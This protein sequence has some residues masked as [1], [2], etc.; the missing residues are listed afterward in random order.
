M[1]SVKTLKFTGTTPALSNHA[2][3]YTVPPLRQWKIVNYLGQAGSYYVFTLNGANIGLPSLSSTIYLGAG[4]ILGLYN[5]HSVSI[6]NADITVMLI[7][8]VADDYIGN[9]AD[10]VTLEGNDAAFFQDASNLNAGTV[11][12]ARMDWDSALTYAQNEFTT[13]LG[14]PYRSLQ[15]SNSNKQPNLNT[16]WWEVVGGGG[17]GQIN[18]AANSLRSANLTG[19]TRSAGT[20]LSWSTATPLYGGGALLIDNFQSGQTVD[21]NLNAVD[22]V[23]GGQAWK[24]DLGFHIENNSTA[25]V[26]GEMTISLLDGS[27]EIQGGNLPVIVGQVSRV[28]VTA[29]PPQTL[30]G[31][32]VRIKA[33]G[34]GKQCDLRIADL[35]VS[36]WNGV[37]VPAV[38][39]G[40]D[41]TPTIENTTFTT[42]YAKM[43]RIG[44]NARFSFRGLATAVSGEIRFNLPNGL[45]IDTIGMANGGIL[46]V[47]QQFNTSSGN[48]IIGSVM[49][50]NSTSK[51]QFR[52][53]GGSSWWS[54]GVPATWDANTIL[55]FDFT[56][57]IAQ[58]SSSIQVSG[59][60][61]EYAYNT[62]TSNADSE[63]AASAGYGPEGVSFGSYTAARRKR[64]YFRSPLKD[65]DEF[66]IQIKIS[67]TSVWTDLI[68]NDPQTGL[69]SFLYQN[70]VA[71]GIGFIR[72]G[73][74]EG[75]NFVTVFFGTYAYA[76]GVYGAAGGAWSGYT[77]HRWRVVKRSGG[78]NAA[79]PPVVRAEYYNADAAAINVAINFSTKSEDTHNAVTIGAGTWKFTAPVSGVY[80]VFVQIQA[81]STHLYEIRKGG[82]AVTPIALFP[83][84]NMGAV[85]G[86]A[87]GS[88]T[89]RLNAGEYID[90]RDITGSNLSY[91]SSS[92]Q[93]VRIGS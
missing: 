31:L 75:S 11:A 12:P 85:A 26:D 79:V 65:S 35:S 82:A 86:M 10:A 48:M 28:P 68:G 70:T 60:D 61:V 92:I 63:T 17:T 41:F 74:Y 81:T 37:S 62:D 23:Y 84:V 87:I 22:P 20:A 58:W 76:S 14:I 25:F 93:I 44:K 52:T 78:S 45:T 29:W 47:A 18:F 71:Y 80:M 83:A 64:V 51:V 54:A 67:G 72:S 46:G 73:S 27:N 30:T 50:N 21:I 53:N 8:Q 19:I 57:P 39:N 59:E 13:Y 2:T 88:K 15:N 49:T 66:V 3:T 55:S 43:Y 42:T 89:V 36:P 6:A 24:I 5:S 34:S 32:K 40:V 4:D 56:V 16:D 90:V 91:A 33:G 69:S 38:D 7:E 77:A 9:I 1:V